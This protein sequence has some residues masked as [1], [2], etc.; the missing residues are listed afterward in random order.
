M[1]KRLTAFALALVMVLALLPLSSCKSKDDS[2]EN[3]EAYVTRGQ[4]ISMLAAAFALDTY[5]ESTPYYADIGGSHDLFPA[6][7][8]T[9]EWDIL[10]I[11]QGD[12]LNADEPVTRSEVASTAAFAAGFKPENSSFDESGQF[13]SGPSIDYAITHGLVEAGD[14]SGFMS[15]EECAAVIELAKSLYLNGDREEKVSVIYNENLVDLAKTDPNFIE[16]TEN[17][18]TFLGEGSGTVTQ[19]GA[20]ELTAS[21]Q[22]EDGV[23][24]LHVGDAFIAPPM[25]GQRTGVAYKVA[26]IEETDRGITFTTEPPDLGDLFDELVLHTTLSLDESCITWADGVTVSPATPDP[27]SQNGQSSGYNIEVLPTRLAAHSTKADYLSDKALESN[28]Y[29]KSNIKQI[30]LGKGA[31]DLLQDDMSSVLEL[32]DALEVLD[33]S[34]FT[35]KGTPSI[36]DFIMPTEPWKKKLTGEKKYST[37][38]KIEGTISLDL[39][40]TP[41]IEYHKWG[42]FGI[43]VPWPESAS[44]TV[45]SNIATALKVEGSLEGSYEIGRISIPTAIPGLTIDGSL[46]LFVGLNGAIQAKVK[47]QNVNRVEWQTPLNF[48]HASEGKKQR[49]AS[50]PLRI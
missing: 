5:R 14:L 24:E 3:L 32:G 39:E 20:G 48:R 50:R 46:S 19:N 28:T 17:S 7:Q 12:T 36:S 45:N 29:K 26:S 23:I 47:F 13:I 2:S 30:T 49:K 1:K 40:V 35:Y 11:F 41:D 33:F 21:I 6:I 34:N 22:T 42:L 8:A 27:L 4:W 25:E 37:D 10:S 16:I 44:L 18:V 9:S 15:E 31:F 38:Y 43:E